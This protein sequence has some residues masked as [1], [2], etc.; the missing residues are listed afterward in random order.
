MLKRNREMSL[1]G[2]VFPSRDSTTYI[3]YRYERPSTTTH[4]VRERPSIKYEEAQKSRV[5]SFGT[6]TRLLRWDMVSGSL[7]WIS[8]GT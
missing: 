8:Y 2:T 3:P 1:N 6:A 7:I 5:S 4:K